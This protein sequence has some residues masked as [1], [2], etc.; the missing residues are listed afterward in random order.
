[1]ETEQSVSIHTQTAPDLR[2][3]IFKHLHH[4]ILWSHTKS[5]LHLFS[6]HALFSLFLYAALPFPHPAVVC[7]CKFSAVM[8]AVLIQ[9]FC[10]LTL[11]FKLNGWKISNSDNLSK[12]NCTQCLCAYVYNQVPVLSCFHINVDA[13]AL[14]VSAGGGWVFFFR[15]TVGC[16]WRC[17]IFILICPRM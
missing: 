4:N 17:V 14:E 15:V 2:H 8:W 6:F 3:V 1:M 11:Q 10:F 13:V 12:S 5:S 9:F 16:G 7:F